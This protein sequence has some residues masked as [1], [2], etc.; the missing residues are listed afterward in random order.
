MRILSPNNGKDFVPI[1]KQHIYVRATDTKHKLFLKDIKISPGQHTW[2]WI[3]FR[4][5]R[6]VD[7]SGIED[8]YCSFDN[9]INRAVN[10][11]YRTVYEFKDQDEMLK[12]LDEIKFIDSITTVYQSKDK[13]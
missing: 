12:H 9:A 1:A 4:T 10:D 8:R 6:S 7:I 2:E 3:S 11:S 13:E 5:D